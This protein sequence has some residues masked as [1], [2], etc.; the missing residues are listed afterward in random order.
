MTTKYNMS[1]LQALQELQNIVDSNGYRETHG[2]IWLGPRLF[3]LHDFIIEH[4]APL[5][6]ET[7]CPFCG[8]LLDGS[9]FHSP[10]EST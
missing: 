7:P 5:Y 1:P 8:V 4:F 3:Q 10:S 9:A 6:S 2:D